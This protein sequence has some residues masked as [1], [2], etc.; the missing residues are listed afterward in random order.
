M[1]SILLITALTATT[2]LFGGGRN[3]GTGRCG[4]PMLGHQVAA[5]APCGG[6]YGQAAPGYG[7]GYGQAAPACG[8]GGYGYAAPYQGGGYAAPAC[9][10]CSTP[11]YGGGYAAPAPSY[12]APAPSYQAPAPH[13]YAPAM[14]PVQTASYNSFYSAPASGGC[15]NGVCPRR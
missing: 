8:G 14:A 3:C 6:G 2:G 11:G 12:Q 7:G 13:A 1:H 9:G 5:S 15:A 10:S 4:S